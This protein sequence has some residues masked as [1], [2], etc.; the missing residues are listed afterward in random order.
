MFGK[1]LKMF[2][3]QPL[4][5]YGDERSAVALPWE[6]WER[7]AQDRGGGVADLFAESPTADDEETGPER[8]P[9]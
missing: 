6:E 5:G 8:P 4:G 3:Y 9:R 2:A 1:D 7:E